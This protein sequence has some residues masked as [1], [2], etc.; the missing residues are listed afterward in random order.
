[1]SNQNVVLKEKTDTVRALLKAM[2]KQLALALPAHLTPD[3][4]VRVTMTAIQ[5]N[6]RL[7]DCDRTSLLA[8]VMTSAQLGLEPDGVLGQAYLVPYGSKVQFIPG[9]KGYLA[10]ARNSGEIS[11]IQAH[12][13]CANDTFGYAYG[14][15]ERLDHVPA[16]GD[17]GEITHFYAY[18]KYKDGGHIFEVLTRA[19]ID[20]TR[21]NSD[22][23]KAFKAKRIKSNPWHSHYTQMGRKTVIRKLAN[24]LP[25]NV[26]RAAVLDAKQA[27]GM[28]ADIDEY[29][30]FVI[31]GE[32][33]TVAETEQSAATGAA[34]ATAKLDKLA[35]GMSGNGADAP[36]GTAANDDKKMAPEE[37]KPPNMTQLKKAI[38]AAQT[39]DEVDI[40]LDLSRHLSQDHQDKVLAVAVARHAELTPNT[41][42]TTEAQT[43]DLDATGEVG[44]GLFGDE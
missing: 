28:K 42:G 20:A 33:E 39:A 2:R 4:L 5:N 34:G 10:L 18:A 21:D 25:L 26:Q 19:D 29:G 8:A 24:Y 37:A 15:N 13:V 32:A 6:P 3:R 35:G 40:Q 7:L 30:E 16:D 9:Y 22:G 36:T 23:Y 38:K 11:T 1:M 14:L 41:Q 17:R 44:G 12:E 31:E 27:A 43:A